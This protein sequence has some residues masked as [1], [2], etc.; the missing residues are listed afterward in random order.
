MNQWLIQGDETANKREKFWLSDVRRPVANVWST[1][2][3]PSRAHHRPVE[4]SCR[5]VDIRTEPKSIAPSTG[6]GFLPTGRQFPEHLSTGRRPPVDRSPER[7][8]VSSPSDVTKSSWSNLDSRFNQDASYASEASM[9]H[10]SYCKA[11]SFR[12][13]GLRP[14]YANDSSVLPPFLQRIHRG[15]L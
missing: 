14:S 6:R 1:G 4:I 7:M 8:I 5:P 15:Y 2:R 12:N 9:A 3:P 13:L 10:R 11:C